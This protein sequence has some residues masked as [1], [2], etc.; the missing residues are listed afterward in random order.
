MYPSG[1]HVLFYRHTV[2]T[3]ANLSIAYVGIA[4]TIR[5]P[6]VT[7][8]A[9]DGGESGWGGPTRPS[10]ATDYYSALCGPCKQS[11]IFRA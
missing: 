1:S 8:Q 3:N 7:R 2:S 5:T 9:S 11:Q 4:V 6:F 10:C